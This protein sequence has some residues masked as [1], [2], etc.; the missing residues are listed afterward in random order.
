MPAAYTTML[1]VQE[2][3]FRDICLLIQHDR[4]KCDSCTSG[5]RFAFGFLQIPPHDEHPC[6]S[7]SSSPCRAC[8]VLPPPSEC[9]LPCAP[10][11]D[12]PSLRLG[13]LLARRARF[14]LATNRLTA[15][16]SATEL[17]PNGVLR[18]P[19]SGLPAGEPYL[20]NWPCW[21]ASAGRTRPVQC[22]KCRRPVNIMLSP[23]SL[24][25]AI[26]SSSRTEPPGCT[27]ALTPAAAAASRPSRNG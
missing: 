20:I 22:R 16:R 2:Q 21:H 8:R 6:R 17:P 9:A 23:C 19:R 1:S 15:D 4:L 27:T 25:A 7:A 12:K 11:R 18:W 24:A 10:K 14:E 5:Q 26:T 3:D 13:F